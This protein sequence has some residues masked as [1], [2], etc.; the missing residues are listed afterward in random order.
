MV[1]FIL[2]GAT[3]AVGSH[4]LYELLYYFM[5]G[6]QPGQVTIMIRPS[7]SSGMSAS[8][9]LEVLLTSPLLP[10]KLSKWP[11]AQL[12]S[13]IHLIEGAFD[14]TPLPDKRSGK[15][16]LIHAAASVN[17][18]TRPD[19]EQDII[20]TNK[21]GTR[22]L[23]HKATHKIDKFVFVSTAFATGHRQGDISDDFS[24]VAT[25]DFRNPYEKYKHGSEKEVAQFCQT[26]QIDYSIV[27]PA[28]VCGRLIDAPLYVLPRYATFY[29]TG[30]FFKKILQKF[31]NHHKVRIQIA[32]DAQLNI[33]PVDYVARVILR[34]CF[35]SIK[36]LNI[37]SEETVE[38]RKII[39]YMLYQTD[40]NK[41]QFQ[42]QKPESLNESE[43][44][45]YETI[46]E[47]FSRYMYTPPHKY[48]T[49]GVKNLLPDI[50]Q[51]NVEPQFEELYRYAAH[52]K[53]RPVV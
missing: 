45:Y 8:Q 2:T 34:A 7:E 39:A 26:H 28:I 38:A 51:P 48:S 20:K 9:R 49:N 41:Y 35:S 10:H 46:G 33:V 22:S 19:I 11:Q 23:L 14:Q 24:K 44:Y 18:G 13:R 1:H 15:T 25:P 31:G 42:E 36:E 52:Q 40:F 5:E 21:Q 53:F 30:I 16:I 6:Q 47:Q 27:R 29:L 4:V 3:G 32:D 50:E 12:L 37:V 17:L 43:A